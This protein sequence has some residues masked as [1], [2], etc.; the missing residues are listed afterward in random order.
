MKR[1]EVN[2]AMLTNEP[3]P[4]ARTTHY[5]VIRLSSELTKAQ[6]QSVARDI[7][8][9]FRVP[10]SQFEFTLRE[11]EEVGNYLEIPQ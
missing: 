5:C 1:Y 4:K 8:N 7:V 11:T 3:W 6:A 9:N 10:G 2:V